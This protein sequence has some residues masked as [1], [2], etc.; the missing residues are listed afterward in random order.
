MADSAKDT[1]YIDVDDEITAIIDKLQSSDSKIVALVLPKRA[2]ALQ[3]IVNMKL[4]KRTAD[5]TGKHP[6]LI[7]SEAGL[8]PI[9]GATGLYVAKN[10]QS[11]PEIPNA[12][13]GRIDENEEIEAD[14]EDPV[15][16]KKAPVGVLAGA[17]AA[18]AIDT[19]EEE[20]SAASAPLASS[21]KA[22]K[23]TKSKG[24]K[25]PKIPNFEKFRKKLFI[26]IGA[27]LALIVLWYLAFF[28]A[29]SAT[30][31]IETDTQPIDTSLEI[32]ASPST[33]ELNESD[34]IAPS[35][36]AE[37][38]EED[39]QEVPATGQKD[40]S[41][42]ASGVVTIRQ[43]CD[44]VGNG[45]VTVPAG[46]GVSANGLTYITQSTTTINNT[47]VGGGNCFSG[48]TKVVAQ[49]NGEQY[50]IGAA[51]YTVSGYSSL[52][53]TGTAMTGG[54]SKTIKVVSDQDVDSAKDKMDVKDDAIKTDL[55]QQLE[56]AGYYAI[57]DS[58][59]K[60]NENTDVSPR[61]GQEATN[62][63]VSYSADFSMVGIKR[64]DLKKLITASMKDK[65]DTEKQTV[66]DDGIDTAKFVIKDTKPNGDTVIAIDT[67]ALVGPDIDQDQLKTDIAGKKSGET[68][69]I[70][71]EFPGVKEAQVKYSPFWVSRTPKKVTKINLVFTS[72]NNN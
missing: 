56:S 62:V 65:I 7:T 13:D 42:K 14:V 35:K 60:S 64:D 16:D 29:P 32:T 6:V 72:T 1:I 2:V 27:G 67:T 47:D 23:K 25:N 69:N 48:L 71:K 3:S 41:A 43:R 45:F 11:K 20:A 31:T 10:L 68:E 53:A 61:V 28:V 12:P 9:A 44:D 40:L 38:K 33:T 37:K 49:N 8:L 57:T 4:L 46:T 26:I 59:K 66:Q 18:S 39:S 58:F 50:N 15:I 30:I 51:T 22:A 55:K 70:I 21:S 5:E 19:N 54:I 63:K 36:L 34:N 24:A 52:S 17:A